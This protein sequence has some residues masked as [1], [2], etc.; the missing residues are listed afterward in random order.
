MMMMMMMVLTT[1]QLLWQTTAFIVSTSHRHVAQSRLSLS[2]RGLQYCGK[3]SL[4]MTSSSAAGTFS[5]GESG[6][7]TG[8]QGCITSST[9][10]IPCDI[11]QNT[12]TATI[13]VLPQEALVPPAAPTSSSSM[14]TSSLNLLKNMVGAGVFSLNSRVMSISTNPMA[15]IPAATLIFTMA[16]W[17]T[18]NFYMVGETCRLTDSAT[19]SE[20]WSKTVSAN[21]QWIIQ[22]VVVISPIVS[23]LASTIVLTDIFGLLLRLIGLPGSVYTNRNVVIGILAT[24]V[25]Y[26]LSILKD[27]S[28][29]KSVS[30]FGIA[31]HL[32]AMGALAVRILDKSYFPGGVFAAPLLAPKKAAN[33]AKA[34][35][36][37]AQKA[38]S[39][40]GGNAAKWLVLASLLSYCFV[41]HYN[42]PKYFN[43]LE[44]KDRN[45][46]QFLKMV[47]TS[48]VNGA[49][50]YIGTCALG[51]ALFGAGSA[52]FALNRCVI[53]HHPTS[54]HIIITTHHHS[55][56]LIIT[57]Q[58]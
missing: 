54:S 45:A 55:S 22:S 19:Y 43:E 4:R 37:A 51:M 27:L 34:A 21:S 1:Q 40:P 23:C 15:I 11:A 10:S 14:R 9:G 56:P 33:A 8:S 31:G 39:A 46:P 5:P 41:T 29:L 18:Y 12:E 26:P 50:I 28:A 24:F 2:A 49:A 47:T 20:A 25:L 57:H 6:I 7:P 42:A 16:M 30:L 53:A 13:A 38:A 36:I 17:A 58:Q 3:A 48:Y 44:E 52:S 35:S 32:T